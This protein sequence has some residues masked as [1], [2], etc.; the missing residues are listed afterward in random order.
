MLM[1][2]TPR[3]AR[4][5]FPSSPTTLAARRRA[6][7][8]QS[9]SNLHA[10]CARALDRFGRPPSSVRS[11]TRRTAR[12][13]ARRGVTPWGDGLAPSLTG[14]PRHLARGTIA[15]LPPLLSS[16]RA[17]RAFF[18]C[19][20]PAHRAMRAHRRPRAPRGLGARSAA[21]DAWA[22]A[23]ARMPCRSRVRRSTATTID[24]TGAA[25]LCTRAARALAHS[26]RARAGGR[27]PRE[28]RPVGAQ[29]G[30]TPGAGRRACARWPTSPRAC[31]CSSS[32]TA[33]RL[34]RRTSAGARLLGAALA[35]NARC[36]VPRTCAAASVP[37]PTMHKRCSMV[38][39]MTYSQEK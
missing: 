28:P 18:R 6:V 23:T 10:R 7:R 24:R 39:R 30:A 32:G 37:D 13:I 11:I 15:H 33:R 21:A 25:C 14:M 29:P 2:S 3:R 26:S 36:R 8:L 4:A 16:V 31:G 19:A 27:G 17:G 9:L 1:P 12:S 35:S 38:N 34:T 5:L 22:A 20:R